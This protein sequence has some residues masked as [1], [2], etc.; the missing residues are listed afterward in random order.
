VLLCIGISAL[1]ALVIACFAG[2]KLVYALEY[3][4]KHQVREIVIAYGIIAILATGALVLLVMIALDRTLMAREHDLRSLPDRPEF[5]DYDLLN[6]PHH[7]EEFDDRPLKS[8]TFTVFDTE[9]TGLRP[10]QGDEIIQIGAVRVQDGRVR[11]RI[12]FDQLVNPGFEIPRA[13]IRFHGITD[14]MVENV[15]GIHP[16]L[17]EFREFIGT[18]IL[19]AHNAA[20]DMKFLK[21]KEQESGIRFDHVVLDTLL[22][23][24]FLD[25]EII[26]HTLSAIA[27]RQGVEI[28]GRHTALG[29]SIATAEILIDM[30]DRLEV[31]GIT[32]LDQ[33]LRASASMVSVRKLQE[34]F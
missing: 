7:L 29:D 14:D 1:V 23:S 32:T 31:R 13:S 30:L 16:A 4:P 33:V 19:V 21:L 3:A 34:Q 11:D 15:P 2:W 28:K 18:S 24:V 12:T 5:Y 25:R 17:K 22:L 27:D 26:E 8:L 9:T 6:L 20:F 10:S